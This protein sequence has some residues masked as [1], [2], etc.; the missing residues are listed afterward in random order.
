M[1]EPLVEHAERTDSELEIG[2]QLCL[3][4]LNPIKV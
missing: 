2:K 3:T 4:A 1:N